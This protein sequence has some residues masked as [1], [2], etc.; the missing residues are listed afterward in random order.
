MLIMF[1][2]PLVSLWFL[3]ISTVSMYPLLLRDG[4]TTSYFAL[5]TLFIILIYN[6]VDIWPYCWLIKVLD[7]FLLVKP[8]I[9][10]YC[11]VR[12]KLGFRIFANHDNIQ[13]LTIDT[14]GGRVSFIYIF[15]VLTA[16]PI[17][18]NQEDICLGLCI[19][20]LYMNSFIHLSFR[21][22]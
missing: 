2:S 4:Q 6:F 12:N 3:C 8:S 13:L 11:R 19:H 18:F 16:L 17:L 5:L 9:V 22:I 21:L 15:T 10:L 7:Y 14:T 1:D 20:F